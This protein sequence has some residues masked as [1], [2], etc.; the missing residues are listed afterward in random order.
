VFLFLTLDRLDSDSG[1]GKVATQEFRAMTE[2]GPAMAVDRKA[3]GPAVPAEPFPQDELMLAKVKEVVKAHRP[4]LVHAYSGCLTRTMDYLKGLGCKVTYTV[5]AHDREISRREHEKLG[6]TFPYPHLTEE[7][8]WQ[9]YIGGYR[10][11]DV[12]VCPSTAAMNVVGGYGSDFHNKQVEVIPHGVD[13]PEEPVKSL[14]K[15]F[16]VGYLGSWG[17]D[18]GVRYLLEAWKKLAYNDGSLLV[19]GGRDSLSA[20]AGHL[21]KTFGGGNIRLLGYVKHVADFYN[22]LSCYCQP[23]A[24]EGCG[25]EI[26]EALAAGRPVLASKNSGGPDYLARDY[27]FDACD[28]GALANLLHQLKKHGAQAPEGGFRAAAENFSWDKIRERY[29][30][31]WRSLL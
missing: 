6:L 22:S 12:I 8:L 3:L 23:S 4:L 26:L 16:V 17:A 7:P 27:C 18:K 20:W 1:G 5:A 29:K 2:L 13:I 19:L 25:L 10:A 21:F 15:S 31:L 24:T 14:P 9:Q 28:P 30:I 11:A